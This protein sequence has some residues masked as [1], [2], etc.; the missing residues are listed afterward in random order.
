MVQMWAP[1]P[2]APH[3]FMGDDD[4]VLFRADEN[5][6]SATSFPESATSLHS[7]VSHH[8]TH[9][10]HAA[11]GKEDSGGTS[12]CEHS[13]RSRLSSLR[14]FCVPAPRDTHTKYLNDDGSSHGARTSLPDDENQKCG[15]GTTLLPTSIDREIAEPASWVQGAFEDF[16]FFLGQ[17]ARYVWSVHH[18]GGHKSGETN[19]PETSEWDRRCRDSV[20]RQV[21]GCKKENPRVCC[22]YTDTWIEYR[23]S[24]GRLEFSCV[25][26]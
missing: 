14:A 7:V 20:H 21:K 6:Q 10:T 18:W 4:S 5:S 11:I 15:A 9:A 26:S 25:L 13:L 3:T 16:R 19:P 8:V 23:V 12:H 2:R 1:A 22:G 17:G 24:L